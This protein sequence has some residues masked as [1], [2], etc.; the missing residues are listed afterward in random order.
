M[1]I[2]ERLSAT[3]TARQLQ[4]KPMSLHATVHRRRHGPTGQTS[5][6][7]KLRLSE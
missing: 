5:Q 4:A 1:N 3:L 2:Y 6:T 7:L